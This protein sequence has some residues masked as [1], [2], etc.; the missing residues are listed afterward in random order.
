MYKG[1]EPGDLLVSPLRAV[2]PIRVHA[3][4]GSG[5]SIREAPFHVPSE[6]REQNF[7]SRDGFVTKAFFFYNVYLRNAR[8]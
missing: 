7:H 8:G 5:A 1:R 4:H 3:S 6:K 2:D